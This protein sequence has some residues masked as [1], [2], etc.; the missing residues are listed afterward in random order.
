LIAKAAVAP[1]VAQTIRS[2]S[3]MVI[4]RGIPLQLIIAIEQVLC[5]G[6]YVAIAIKA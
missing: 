1:F 3:Q 2:K 5:V 6:F 4:H